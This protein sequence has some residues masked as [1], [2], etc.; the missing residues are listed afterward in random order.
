MEKRI[1]L[2][3]VISIALLALWSVAVPKFFP[4]LAK[5]PEP[6]RPQVARTTT[7]PTP[8]KPVDPD[9]PAPVIVPPPSTA[10]VVAAAVQ[11]STVDTPEFTAVF[12]NRG[13]QLVSFRLKKYRRKD[14]PAQSVDLVRTREANR[15]DFPFMIEA[16]D[17]H[18]AG[19]FN[20]ALY[21]VNDRTDRSGMRVIDY[22]YSDGRHTITK[23]FRFDAARPYLFDFSTNIQPPL[24]YRVAVGPGIRNIGPEEVDSGS[25]IT[26]NGVVQTEGKF[27]V[28]RREKGDRLQVFETIDYIGIEDNYFL[29]VLR[30][31]SGGEGLL[32]RE[33]YT[34]PATKKKR[35]D[36]FAAVNA[37][38]EGSVAG[39]AFFGPKETKVLDAYDFGNALQLGW[40]GMIAR[41][42]LI[43]LTWLN[44]FTHNYGWA[45]VVLTVMIKIVL[46]PL[47]HKQNVSMKKM[48]R[49]GPKV[50]AI[51]A[52]YKKS[53]TDAEQRNKM[54]VEMMA[55]YQKE[56]I[57]PMAGCLP[58]VI[59]L[60]ILWGFYGLLSRA[61]EL[62]GAP[63]MLWIRDLSE[64]D[65]TY[66]LPIFM[67][68]TMFLQTYLTPA[69]GDPAQR[70]MFLI[71]PLVF[72]FMFKDF[73]SGLVLYWFV[74]NILTIIQQ[75]IMNKWWKDHPDPQPATT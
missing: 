30:P 19:R 51:K 52:K 29:T 27:K 12:S 37:G 21:A 22:R 72:G 54:N 71:M 6:T 47:Q 35:P 41:F 2:A 4:E 15:T 75:L 31:S 61:I 7:A 42:F 9:T 65:P 25:V 40:F 63:W 44:Q 55:L 66:V 33:S 3:V 14:V 24:P 39:N 49:V 45:I 57:N 16:R 17:Q 20:S 11:T 28:L 73:P 68:A 43:A 13:A 70:K 56:G 18:L 62:R 10:P 36:F 48:Q 26:G 50:E 1:F 69:T 46:Y 38:A 34:D 5:K 23:S 74:Q 8:A 60:P 59:Q 64:K 67:T 53:K 32:H 58:L